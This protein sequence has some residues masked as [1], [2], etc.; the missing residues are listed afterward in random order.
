MLRRT[1]FA[2]LTTVAA[3][4]IYIS[5]YFL[6]VD[7]EFEAGA[8]SAGSLT[9]TGVHMRTFDR[10]WMGFIYE[11]LASIEESL[12]GEPVWICHLDDVAFTIP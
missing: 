11:P 6:L 2:I 4:A 5:G 9:A 12:R 3:V 8:I 10:A 1:G 7:Y